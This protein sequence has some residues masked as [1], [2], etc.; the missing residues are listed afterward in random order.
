[1][2]DRCS[3]DAQLHSLIPFAI[4]QLVGNDDLASLLDFWVE[5]HLFVTGIV[6]RERVLNDG[7]EILRNFFD[8]VHIG[9]WTTVFV[10]VRINRQSQCFQV[11]AGI[12]PRASIATAASDCHNA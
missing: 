4:A 5:R 10:D 8:L 11:I 1:M 12:Y 6:A 9:W 7:G 3:A 2:A